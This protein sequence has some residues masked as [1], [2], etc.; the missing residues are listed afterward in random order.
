MTGITALIA[1][2]FKELKPAMSELFA[3]S[4]QDE[5]RQLESALSRADDITFFKHRAINGTSLTVTTGGAF[6][7]AEDIVKGR[8]KNMWCYVTKSEGALRRQITLGN[9]DRKT[10]PVYENFKSIPQMELR[11]IGLTVERLKSIARSHC[12]FDGFDPL[13]SA[14]E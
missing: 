6:S 1:L 8:A 3:A 11:E 7:S 14:V 5:Q 10:S 4:K 13:S 2:D 12:Q 9:R